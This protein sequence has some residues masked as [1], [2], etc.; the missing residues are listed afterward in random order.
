MFPK[1]EKKIVSKHKSHMK[2]R[3]ENLSTLSFR[4]S[5]IL[6]LEIGFFFSF[7]KNPEKNWFK[8]SCRNS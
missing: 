5:E 2:K 6:A 4:S 3:A 7:G 8:G 1:C